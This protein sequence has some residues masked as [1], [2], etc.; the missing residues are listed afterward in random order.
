MFGLQLKDIIMQCLSVGNVIVCDPEHKTEHADEPEVLGYRLLQ[1]QLVQA[2]PIEPLD[3]YLAG[4]GP[5]QRSPLCS[6]PWSSRQAAVTLV[7][8][9]AVAAL[10]W[11]HV[12]VTSRRLRSGVAIFSIT[13]KGL[14]Y[15]KG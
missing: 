4:P 8:S 11:R 10:F 7:C 3:S 13:D 15:R 9:V 14:G 6:G 2:A 12:A 5:S 1:L